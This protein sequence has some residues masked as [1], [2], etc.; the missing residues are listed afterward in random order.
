MELHEIARNCM[1]L[2]FTRAIIARN[3]IELHEIAFTKTILPFINS[4]S[5]WEEVEFS[6]V[7]NREGEEVISV[8]FSREG[9]ISSFKEYRE[10]IN[11]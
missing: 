10:V 7:L 11:K 2:H 4:I 5:F 6:I 9:R 3:C 8:I 1:E